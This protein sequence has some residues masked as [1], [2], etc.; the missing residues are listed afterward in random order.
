MLDGTA[1]VTARRAGSAEI[2]NA[3]TQRRTASEPRRRDFLAR[4]SVMSLTIPGHPPNGRPS[5]ETEA[6][7]VAGAWLDLV[8]SGRYAVVWTAAAP[9]LREAIDEEEWNVALRSVRAPLGSCR[10]R[11]L[12]SRETVEAFPGLPPGPY[13]VIH[14]ESDFDGRRGVV[15]T[16]TTSLGDDGRWRAIAYFVR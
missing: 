6:T 5:P 10:S 16:V 9:A 1:G 2:T 14:F 3:V 7:A 12:R 8:D 13:T 15:E 4:L 11:N